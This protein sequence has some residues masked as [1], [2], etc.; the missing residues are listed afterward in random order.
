[1]PQGKKIDVKI[2]TFNNQDQFTTAR[3]TLS[4]TYF[5]NYSYP[6]Q[7]LHPQ[8][9]VFTPTQTDFSS[10]DDFFKT[11]I[12]LP[13]TCILIKSM[14]HEGCRQE[15]LEE[16]KRAVTSKLEPQ[17][18]ATPK[19]PALQVALDLLHQ[20]QALEIVKQL[21][22]AENLIVEV[23]TPLIKAEGIKA[24]RQVKMA[25]P[26]HFVVADLKTLDTGA[27]EVDIAAAAGADAIAIS[28]LGNEATINAAIKQAHLKNKWLILDML[29]VSSPLEV[30]RALPVS[31]DVVL[32]HRG[33][34]MEA[35][36]KH[37]FDVLARVKHEF[38]QVK[39]AIA[40]GITLKDVQPAVENGA[41]II[42]VGRAIT[43]SQ[44]IN[45][46]TIEFLQH[47]E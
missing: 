35:S 44:N 31:P 40:G 33:I 23:G 36:Q 3:V 8:V 11:L 28:G 15:C 13:Y 24:V 26:N 17:P 29:N 9:L 4:S 14:P 2:F 41:D 12:G 5:E 21:P 39:V 27:L 42:I 37:R 30:L 19:L 38:P 1:M 10:L 6:K 32:L 18:A 25:Y 43:Q 16:I 7:T 46:A 45:A 20:E 22:V 34:D 47:L